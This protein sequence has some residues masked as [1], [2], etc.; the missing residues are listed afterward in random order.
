MGKGYLSLESAE[1][2]P[3][4]KTIVLVFRNLIGKTLY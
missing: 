3:G 4:K 2:V 1:F